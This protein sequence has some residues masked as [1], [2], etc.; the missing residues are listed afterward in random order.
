MLDFCSEISP[1]PP[2]LL[3][4]R[5]D[6]SASGTETPAPALTRVTTLEWR[7]LS[8]TRCWAPP[9]WG[10]LLPS[11]WQPREGTIS[12][13]WKD[14]DLGWTAVCSVL[15]TRQDD[16][17]CSAI[18]V[19][20]QAYFV[21]LL[22]ETAPASSWPVKLYLKYPLSCL[23]CQDCYSKSAVYKDTE[24]GQRRG[25]DNSVVV[26]EKPKRTGKA[27]CC[28]ERRVNFPSTCELLWGRQVALFSTSPPSLQ[29]CK[30]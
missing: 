22:W 28:P 21:P 16:V 18:S 27:W 23:I 24:V 4:G 26:K 8:K 15:A 10:C 30:R 9:P 19:I 7:R 6:F 13:L 1:L 14:R 11:P 3:S 5:A 12:L 2:R 29:R 25:T 20:L 17:A